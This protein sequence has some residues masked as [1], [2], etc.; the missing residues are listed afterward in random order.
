MNYMYFQKQVHIYKEC[1]AKKFKTLYI[2]NVLL[3]DILKTDLPVTNMYL[4]I[5]ILIFWSKD[6]VY[7]K[8]FRLSSRTPHAFTIYYDVIKYNFKNL[9]F[10]T[11]NKV[12]ERD[13]SQVS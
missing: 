9:K 8:T 11:F 12:K 4:Y 3:M 5:L 2:Y 1:A 10:L 7:E 13:H 6:L